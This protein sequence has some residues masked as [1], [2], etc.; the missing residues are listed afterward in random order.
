M[1]GCEGAPGRPASKQLGQQRGAGRWG[2]PGSDTGPVPAPVSALTARRPVLLQP[3]VQHAAEPVSEVLEDLGF[4]AALQ[5]QW[6]P[7]QGAQRLAGGWRARVQVGPGPGSGLGFGV[8]GHPAPPP[9]IEQACGP[10]P[11][12]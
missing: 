2:G 6:V 5:G 7:L 8:G 12:F 3:L 10:G 9:G 1:L 11:T 4:L